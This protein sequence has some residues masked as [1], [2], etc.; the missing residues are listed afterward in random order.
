[1]WRSRMWRK[2]IFKK[3]K[4]KYTLQI[5][6]VRNSVLEEINNFE[7]KLLKLNPEGYDKLFLVA[8]T[9]T[10][11][12]INLPNDKCNIKYVVNVNEL[13]TCFVLN[14]L[15]AELNIKDIF[16][17]NTINFSSKP[18]KKSL[19]S[20]ISLMTDNAGKLLIQEEIQQNVFIQEA[21]MFLNEAI[22][23]ENKLLIQSV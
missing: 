20:I 8:K 19:T 1:M 10:R 4:L 18:Y 5:D 2:M 21:K 16:I 17:K 15:I 11:K 12:E 22:K 3:L 14:N 13:D 9:T 7:K 6:N 23:T